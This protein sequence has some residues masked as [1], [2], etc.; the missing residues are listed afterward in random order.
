MVHQLM[1]AV[2]QTTQNRVASYN[3]YFAP[4][5]MSLQFGLKSA[6][7]SYALVSSQLAVEDV[8]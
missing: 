3:N 5:S 1:F 7:L 4:N 6:G 8:T 2:Q